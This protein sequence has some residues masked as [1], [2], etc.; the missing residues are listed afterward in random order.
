MSA[1]LSH[2]VSSD[3]SRTET[4][5]IDSNYFGSVWVACV[6]CHRCNAIHD[7]GLKGQSN[8]IFNLQFFS[9]SWTIDQVLLGF[10]TSYS[11]T[12]L[13][14]LSL[15]KLTPYR[16]SFNPGE[17]ESPTQGRLTHWRV[18]FWSVIFTPYSQFYKLQIQITQRVLKIF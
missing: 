14:I 8:E 18:M 6:F 7:R 3:L 16:V 2:T 12:L 11:G 10:H 17:I 4:L 13:Q 9:S 1:A 5:G 15:K